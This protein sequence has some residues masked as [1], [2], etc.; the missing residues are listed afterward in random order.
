MPEKFILDTDEGSF[1]CRIL[2]SLYQEKKK[3]HYLVY[4]YVDNSNDDIYVS[5]YDPDSEEDDYIL[6]DVSDPQE[7]EEVSK[8]FEEFME[9]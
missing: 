3:K 9:Q 4:E 8:L 7:L 1:E 5:E 2:T 6:N